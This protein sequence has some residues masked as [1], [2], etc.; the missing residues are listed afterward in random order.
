MATENIT[1]IIKTKGDK[2]VVKRFKEIGQAAEDAQKQ[3]KS[4]GRNISDLGKRSTGGVRRVDSSVKKVESSVRRTDTA[5]KQFSRTVRKTGTDTQKMWKGVTVPSSV[6]GSIKSLVTLLA[7]VQAV[8]GVGVITDEFIRM[9]NTLRGF[10]TA[11]GAVNRVRKQINAI[12]IDARVSATE[13]A[14]LYGRLRLATRDFGTSQKEVLKVT[15]TVSKALRLSGSSGLEASQSIRQLS[16]AFNKGKLDGDEFRSVMENAPIIQKLLAEQLGVTKQSLFDMAQAGKITAKELTAALTEGAK[17]IEEQFNKLGFTFEDVFKNFVTKLREAFGPRAATSVRLLGSLLEKIGDNLSLILDVLI[18]IAGFKVFQ[19]MAKHIRS[20]TAALAAHVALQKSSKIL[21]ATPSAGFVTE[22]AATTAHEKNLI[23]AGA[24]QQTF[25][26]RELYGPPRELAPGRATRMGGFAAGASRVG[27]GIAK[28]APHAMVAL[29]AYDLLDAM[30]L[31]GKSAEEMADAARAASE[32]LVS[33]KMKLLA[34]GKKGIAL[35]SAT[36][37][38]F[39]GRAERDRPDISKSLQAARERLRGGIDVEPAEILQAEKSLKAVE[40]QL[41]E[42]AA[43]YAARARQGLLDL[44]EVPMELLLRELEQTIPELDEMIKLS[45]RAAATVAGPGGGYV[46]GAKLNQ[47][48]LDRFP[49]AEIDRSVTE[50]AFDSKGNPLQKGLEALIPIFRKY[51]DALPLTEQEK[52]GNSLEKSGESILNYQKRLRE[53]KDPTKVFEGGTKALGR[54]I[55]YTQEQIDKLAGGLKNAM[56]AQDDLNRI[57][58]MLPKDE[59]GIKGLGDESNVLR[60]YQAAVAAGAAARQAGKDTEGVAKAEKQAALEAI[61]LIQSLDVMKFS[62]EEMLTPLR[63]YLKAQADAKAADEAR[64]ETLKRMKQAIDAVGKTPSQLNLEKFISSGATKSQIDEFKKSDRELGR[65]G[66]EQ[67]VR[68]TTQEYVDAVNLFR[69]EAAR[70]QRDVIPTATAEQAK[71]INEGLQK[72]FNELKTIGT[73]LGET[74]GREVGPASKP[75][76]DQMQTALESAAT[77]LGFEAGRS[78]GA[79]F[80]QGL[81]GAI[82]GIAALTKDKFPTGFG[83]TGTPAEAPESTARKA[84]QTRQATEGAAASARNLASSTRDARIQY[85]ALGSAALPAL[86]NLSKSAKNTANEIQNFFESAFGTL[87]DALVEF[88]TTGEFDFKKFINAIIAD[89]ARLIVRMLIIKPLMSL[90]GGFFGFAQGGLVPPLRY[91]SGGTVPKFQSGGMIA[92]YGG[93][94]SDRYPVMA[95]PGEGFFSV[96]AM[97]RNPIVAREIMAGKKVRKKV[98]GGGGAVAVTYA[99]VGNVEGGPGG[100]GEQQGQEITAVIAR[101]KTHPS[102]REMR[103]N[104]ALEGISRREFT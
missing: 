51:R 9:N 88:V 79:A 72:D 83:F 44:A 20:A 75:F 87:E 74:L 32:E 47:L 63:D 54:A 92:G 30:G 3:V 21:S 101:G 59:Q 28:F 60:V 58:S 69:Q 12:A 25:V 50:G 24:M 41:V 14:T 95:S 64:I 66:V 103:P 13:T 70:I 39:L 2:R 98:G 86:D 90:F 7:G 80:Q 49:G 65:R 1:I 77:T 42:V 23:A 11:E 15:S 55:G 31:F 6:T 8:R 76:I 94:T 22:M 36:A 17:E 18:T 91:A 73:K 27:A 104:G 68:K 82:P 78:F 10:G 40:K 35:S 99:P 102:H 16:Q 5:V 52:L 81:L 61:G 89:L 26:S 84:E 34:G 19:F 46:A 37:E 100:G 29:I 53:L 38:D 33:A 48:L 96:A 97:K 4:L 85:E 71:K 43:D 57:L 62:Y 56:S 45:T 67:S 93:S